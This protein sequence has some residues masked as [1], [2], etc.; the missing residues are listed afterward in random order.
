[1]LRG[2]GK[3]TSFVFHDS[4]SEA[5]QLILEMSAFELLFIQLKKKI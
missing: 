2:A 3:R 1:V 5:K 4:L